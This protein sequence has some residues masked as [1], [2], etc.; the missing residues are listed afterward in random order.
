MA[1]SRTSVSLRYLVVLLMLCMYLLPLF[2]LFNVSMKTQI[3]Y[4]KSPI[5][6]F[7]QFRFGNFSLAWEKGDFSRYI[8]NS[9][10]YTVVTML[11]SILLSLFAAFPIARRY[12]KFSN[13]IYLFFTMSLFLPSP[14]V[15]QFWLANELGLYNTQ[16]GYMLLR[17]GG[18]GIAF[19]MFVGYIKSV[20]RD[21]DE[22]AAIDGCGYLRFM[23]NILIPLVKPVM[24]TGIMLTAIGVWNDI[25]GPTIYLSDTKYQPIT[26]G[27]FAFFGQYLNNWPLLACGIIIIA[28][29]LIVLYVFIQ[30]YL[31]SGALAGSVKF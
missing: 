31:V 4:L 13:V 11:A 24:A 23:F 8:W 18:T 2:Y 20:S 6:L 21:L 26:R 25:I 12:V 19:L 7:E 9:V 28:A 17:T 22:A 10:L 16:W 1:E 15:P 5:S 27:L 14:L 3:E 30:R 29:P